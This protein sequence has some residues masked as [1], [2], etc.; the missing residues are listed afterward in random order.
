LGPFEI[1]GLKYKSNPDVYLVI[2]PNSKR[3]WSINVNKL[4]PFV[5]REVEKLLSDDLT[6]NETAD[7]LATRGDAETALESPR[8]DLIPQ[9]S[10]NTTADDSNPPVPS[11]DIVPN[12]VRRNPKR[13][14]SDHRHRTGITQAE[15]KKAKQRDQNQDIEISMD[16]LQEHVLESIVT[17]ER[18]KTNRIKYL[19][20]WEG[21]DEPSTITR[22]DFV[23][24]QILL[25]YWRQYPE[26]DRPA[27][28]RSKKKKTRKRD[29]GQSPSKEGGE[30]WEATRVS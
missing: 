1:L 14:A 18:D 2:D 30:C 17:H 22:K 28:F 29:R 25:E 7:R 21:Y 13:H 6:G 9:M 23:S 16:D 26:K 8:T 24:K 11:S 15:A 4:R 12:P 5:E 3:E 10:R 19:V 20:K 27:E